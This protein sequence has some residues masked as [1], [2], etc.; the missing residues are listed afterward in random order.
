M[1]SRILVK[2]VDEA[3]VPAII[4]LVVRVVAVVV[5]GRYFGMAIEIGATGFVY[6]DDASFLLVNSYSTLAMVC[7]IAVGLFY[8]LLKSKFFHNTHIHPSVTARLFTMR[9]SS[10]IQT[11]FDI[12]SQGVVWLSYSFLLMFA[13]GL[14]L[15]FGLIYNW[16]FYV[17]LV[18]SVVSTYLLIIDIEK[19]MHVEN[20]DVVSESAEVVL[21]WEEEG[22]D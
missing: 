10:V 3:I 11:S 21:T 1:F 12:Y 15:Y 7:V 8:V 16:I 9:L 6:P 19:E 20:G 22:I 13:S 2:L 14:M 18:L 5:V 4:L 17:S